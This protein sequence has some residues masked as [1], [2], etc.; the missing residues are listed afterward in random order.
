MLL[1]PVPLAVSVQLT[2]VTIAVFLSTVI[3]TALASVVWRERPK[4]GAKAMAA[5]AFALA[6]WSGGQLVVV[7][8][9]AVWLAVAGFTV[10]YLGQTLVASAWYVFGQQ[11]TGRIKQVP[12][13]TLALLAI[14]PLLLVVLAATNGAHELL[15]SDLT[16]TG[17]SVRGLSYG[18]GVLTAI[19]I[20][21]AYLLSGAGTWYLAGKFLTT[22]N[23][24]RTRTLLFIVIAITVIVTSAVSALGLSPVPYF[25]LTPIGFLGLAVLSF[26]SVMSNRFVAAVPLERVL[27]VFGSRSK[28][29]APV[30]RDTAIEEMSTG[31]I[32]TDHKNRVVDVNPIGKHMFGQQHDRVVGKKLTT[33]LPP[34]L[35]LR[36]DT[37]FLQP[38]AT[39]DYTGIWVKTPDGEEHCFDV[40]IS[41]LGR[42]GDE[43]FRG[44]VGLIHD[45]TEQ[46]R[47]RQKLEQRTEQLEHQNEQLE[48]FASIVSHDLRNPLN[49]AK[50][51]IGMVEKQTDAAAESVG[52][53]QNAL[54]RMEDIIGDVL[55]LARLGQSV[56]DTEQVALD[57]LVED[58][59][60]NVDTPRA[61]LNCDLQREVGGD[62]SRLLQLFE[63][64]FRNAIEHG[65]EDVTVTVGPLPD[66]FYV[67]DDGPGIPED[68]QATVFEEGF[69]T[70]E[71]GTGLGLSIA[72]T[73]VD[74]HGWDISVTTGTDDGARFEIRD[75]TPPREAVATSTT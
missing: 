58:A 7:S 41:P 34:E 3:A 59:W 75:V 14:E 50:G 36:E 67:E 2:G 55:T 44:R 70:N 19:H 25:T 60:E 42:D 28:N 20:A 45:V 68:K 56:S 39:G 53:V 33:M 11:Y 30:A 29:L 52:K 57:N 27:A 13:R 72:D 73:I 10:T 47:R 8:S 35:V 40:S 74:A 4:T 51:H 5:A 21:Y 32:V 24:Y 66:G 54:D 71:D 49:V 6:L 9:D 15:W 18:Y 17:G 62:E 63:N 22:R 37:E 1:S 64:L 69:T 12:R 61:Q 38:D 31:F 65:H 48:N 26:L 43:N 23:V 46:E 16:V